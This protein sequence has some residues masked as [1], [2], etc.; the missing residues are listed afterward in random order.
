MDTADMSPALAC[1]RQGK[2]R[3][4]S[5]LPEPKASCCP[6]SSGDKSDLTVSIDAV[7]LLLAQQVLRRK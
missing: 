3:L 5:D 4:L 6:K 1:P 7:C 2:R